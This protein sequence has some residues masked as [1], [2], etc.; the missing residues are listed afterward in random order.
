[1]SSESKFE[2]FYWDPFH[3]SANNT[4]TYDYLSLRCGCKDNLL[5]RFFHTPDKNE[6]SFSPCDKKAHVT[7][8]KILVQLIRMWIDTDY[9]GMSLEEFIVDTIGRSKRK[10]WWQ[11]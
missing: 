2:D 7:Q 4:I 8:A 9:A 1:M 11:L 3:I 5:A 6:D 10:A